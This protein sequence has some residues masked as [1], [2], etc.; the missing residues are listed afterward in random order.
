MI[1]ALAT[2]DLISSLHCHAQEAQPTKGTL[3]HM[4]NSLAKA[5]VTE[6]RDMQGPKGSVPLSGLKPALLA[7][8]TRF[9]AA[10]GLLAVCFHY[11]RGGMQFT[12]WCYDFK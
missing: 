2:G 7:G 1:S 4:A 8:F 12:S 10:L 9:S 11:S 3:V 6:P 5:E